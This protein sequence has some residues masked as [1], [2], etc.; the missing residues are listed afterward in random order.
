MLSLGHNSEPSHHSSAD[1]E[2]SEDW[3]GSDFETDEEYNEDFVDPRKPVDWWDVPYI[4]CIRE[5]ARFR[6]WLQFFCARGR[7]PSEEGPNVKKT[8]V[9]LLFCVLYYTPFLYF[10]THWYP[11]TEVGCSVGVWQ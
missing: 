6:E 1:N 10:F 5:Y 3:S 4:D 7:M 9:K 8:C 11:K 2:G